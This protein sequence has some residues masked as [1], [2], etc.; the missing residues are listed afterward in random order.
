[1][2]SPKSRDFSHE[3]I[4][5]RV[6]RFAFCAGKT[7]IFTHAWTS[8]SFWLRLFYT[9]TALATSCSA[10]R[11]ASSRGKDGRRRC[12]RTNNRGPMEGAERQRYHGVPRR[13][14]VD[15]EAR[16][17]RDD[18]RPLLVRGREACGAVGGNGRGIVVQCPHSLRCA[19]DDRLGWDARRITT[20]SDMSSPCAQATGVS[21]FLWKPSGGKSCTLGVFQI[22]RRARKPVVTNE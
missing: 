12:R 2:A 1:M 22:D 14:D 13:R 15:G 21:L 5:F 19:G 6:P 7:F 3:L 11:K 9:S 18:P 16:A 8:K 17:G 10:D 20:A 4:T